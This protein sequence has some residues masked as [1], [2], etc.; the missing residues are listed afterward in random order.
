MPAFSD[1]RFFPTWRAS[2]APRELITSTVTAL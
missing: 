2:L 1:P